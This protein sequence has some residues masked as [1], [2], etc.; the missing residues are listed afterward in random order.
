MSEK[1]FNVRRAL[2]NDNLQFESYD[3][4]INLS[5]FTITA[6]TSSSVKELNKKT[7]ET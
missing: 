5:Q 3:I 6:A 7:T 4:T 2:N 1:L